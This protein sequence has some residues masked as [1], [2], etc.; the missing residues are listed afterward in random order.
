[1]QT[2]KRP[3]SPHMQIYRPQWTWIPSITHRLTGGLITAGALLL[4]YWLVALASGPA[5]FETARDF[6][7]SVPMLIV[8][9]LLTFC[10][11]YHLLN[12]VRHLFWDFGSGLTVEKVEFTAKLILA[13][14]I[15]LTIGVWVLGYA[16]G[17]A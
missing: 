5:A 10:V 4:V 11:W 13:L 16:F 9:F 14:S 2:D 3:L 15:V 6:F 17:G 8:L 7:G 12:G 1:M